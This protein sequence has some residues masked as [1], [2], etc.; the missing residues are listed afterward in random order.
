MLYKLGKMAR[1]FAYID[2][3]IEGVVKV[4]DNP[5]KCNH[6]WDPQKP[7]PATSPAPCKVY[8]I[9]NNNPVK[10]IDFVHAF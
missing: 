2:D 5:D 10:L 8:N 3:I 9:G 1:D 4:L 6:N 7:D